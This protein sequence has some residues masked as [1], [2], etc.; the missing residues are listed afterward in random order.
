M[1]RIAVQKP[2]TTRRSQAVE[3]LPAYQDPAT[4]KPHIISNLRETTGI[5]ERLNMSA[6]G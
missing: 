1:F 2:E 5:A 6:G 4:F 3:T